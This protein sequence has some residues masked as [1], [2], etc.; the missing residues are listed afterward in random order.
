[1]TTFS[2]RR[3][4]PRDAP[5]PEGVVVVERASTAQD[6]GPKFNRTASDVVRFLMGLGE[7]PNG[8]AESLDLV[9]EILAVNLAADF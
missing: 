5:I 7:M 3:A 9:P 8:D 4:T 1:M 2:I 6:L